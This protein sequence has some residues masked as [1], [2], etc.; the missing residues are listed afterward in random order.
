MQN[1]GKLGFHLQPD[2]EPDGDLTAVGKE[3]VCPKSG[4]SM[5]LP[6]RLGDERFTPSQYLSRGCPSYLTTN[7]L[8]LTFVFWRLTILPTACTWFS[9]SYF[10]EVVVNFGAMIKYSSFD[11]MTSPFPN[12]SIISLVG[13]ITPL[14]STNMNSPSSVFIEPRTSRRMEPSAIG[15]SQSPAGG[16]NDPFTFGP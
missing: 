1:E 12:R 9:H 15:I 13:T 4:S 16:T 5:P 14:N 8:Y 10:F 2:K 11:P 7:T 6:S 3:R